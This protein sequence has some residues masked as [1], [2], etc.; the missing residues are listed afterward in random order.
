MPLL[1]TVLTALLV[2]RFSNHQLRARD[3]SVPGSAEA[4]AKGA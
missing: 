1:V 3:D 4:C 2:D